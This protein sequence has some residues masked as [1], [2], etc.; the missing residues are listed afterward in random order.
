MRCLRCGSD[1]RERRKFCA[2]C[3]FPL[4]H[5]C[6]QCGSSYEPAEDFCGECGAALVT[7]QTR[8][9]QSP[10]A[11]V[12]RSDIRIAPERTDGSPALE[13]E[14]KTVTALFADIKGSTELMEDLDPEQVQAIVDPPLRLMMTW[15]FRYGGDVMVSFRSA[16]R[17]R[18]GGQAPPAPDRVRL[19]NPCDSILLKL[20]NYKLEQR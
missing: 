10:T 12:A 16:R 20:I 4:A 8:G 9:G 11:A 13:G 14:R 5:R 6:P 15:S 17:P 18:L 7:T 3:G 1:N 19:S 2:K